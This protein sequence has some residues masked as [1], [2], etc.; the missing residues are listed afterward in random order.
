MRVLVV[1]DDP[2]LGELVSK[3]LREQAY[4]VDLVTD[5]E[6]AL[7]ESSVNEYDAI[8][9]DVGLPQLSG[10]QVAAEL[11]RRGHQTP[12]LM[13]TAR[14]AV[15]DRVTGLD[16]GADDYL[17]K[18]FD[19]AELFARLRAI[20]RRSPVVL[21]DEIVVDDLVIDT[22]SQ[23]ARRGDQPIALTA[24]EFALLELL[25]RRAGAVVSRA[26][27]VSHVWDENHDPGTNA[28][29]VYINRLRRKVDLP[30]HAPLIH[31]R[32]GAGYLLGPSPAAR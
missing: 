8:V 1:E 21:P 20:L 6:A 31:T 3:G 32:R 29:E 26:V 30:G 9:L 22:R 27:I 25:G 28:I 5:G 16:A 18:P 24:K 13:L 19:F 11:R 17:T 2:R 23:Q 7:V 12:I 14:D 15:P 10:Y 4:A